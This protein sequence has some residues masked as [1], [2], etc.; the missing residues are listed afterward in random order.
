[1]HF[2][3][4]VVDIDGVEVLPGKLPCLNTTNTSKTTFQSQKTTNASY[5]TDGAKIAEERAAHLR[6]VHQSGDTRLV[7]VQSR[8]RFLPL[9]QYL[10][11][12]TFAGH[13]G[14]GRGNQ[15]VATSVAFSAPKARV[16]VWRQ[17]ERNLIPTVPI[18]TGDLAQVTK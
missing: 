3:T 6:E 12:P 10:I 13:I 11:P 17:R 2:R 7:P 5:D 15:R 9:R 8:K 4:W 18:K 14:I 16:A 1:M